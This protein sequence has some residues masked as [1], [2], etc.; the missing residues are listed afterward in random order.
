MQVTLIA[1]LSIN[2]PEFFARPDF[3]AC[4]DLQKKALTAQISVFLACFVYVYTHKVASFYPSPDH[5]QSRF[6]PDP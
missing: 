2:V 3:R 6:L 5:V 1:A 4:L